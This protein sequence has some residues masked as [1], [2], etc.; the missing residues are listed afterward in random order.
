M[1]NA[2]IKN[3]RIEG[4][5]RVIN[6]NANLLE[7]TVVYESMNGSATR[8]TADLQVRLRRPY[9]PVQELYAPLIDPEARKQ[10][11]DGEYFNPVISA[12]PYAR[13][14]GESPELADVV[15]GYS[16][17]RFVEQYR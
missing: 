16:K 3:A 12:F 1:T 13:L 11:H 8:K 5:P 10:I 7:V 2:T 9:D 4:K 6:P 14:N 17:N 15:I